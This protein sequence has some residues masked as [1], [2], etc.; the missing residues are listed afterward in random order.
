MGGG[1]ERTYDHLPSLPLPSPQLH[2]DPFLRFARN[3]FRVS[4][5]GRILGSRSPSAVAAF[6]AGALTPDT[7]DRPC[8]KLCWPFSPL[9][10]PPSHTTPPQKRI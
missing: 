6:P 3:Y 2:S 8:N 9:L 10:Y 4:L 5:G 7:D 1:N